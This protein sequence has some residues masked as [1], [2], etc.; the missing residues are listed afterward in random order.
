MLN[1]VVPGV[2]GVITNSDGPAN[3]AYISVPV[4][5]VVTAW[6]DVYIMASALK[7]IRKLSQGML[8]T[9]A[10]VSEWASTCSPVMH[11]QAQPRPLTSG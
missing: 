8:T 11:A 2:A 7:T 5:I 10:G 9:A 4:G 1:N 6:A 3:T